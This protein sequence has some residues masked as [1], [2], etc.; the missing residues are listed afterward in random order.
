[1]NEIEN[2]KPIIFLNFP[3]RKRFPWETIGTYQN[4]LQKKLS[5]VLSEFR[6]FFK[7]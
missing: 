2:Q 1:M 7:L 4:R 5:T 3:E 6:P